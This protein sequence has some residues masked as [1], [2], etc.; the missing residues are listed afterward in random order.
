VA[1]ISL[2]LLKQILHYNPDTG[3]WTNLVKRSAKTRIGS[4]AGSLDKDGYI[5]IIIKG[6][7]YRSGRLAWFYMTGDWPARKVDHKD[8][9]PA[10][11]KW[12]NLRLA[13]N[14]QNGANRRVQTNNFIGVKGVYFNSRCRLRPYV[15][16]IG[17]RGK[18]R[19]LGSFSTVEEASEAYQRAAYQIFG[20]FARA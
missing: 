8:T 2:E 14:S 9:N 15:A 19:Y 11:D 1:E 17:I 5:I 18:Q 10:N 7:H 16:G 6:K 12:D 4:V 20:E 3:I 13:T